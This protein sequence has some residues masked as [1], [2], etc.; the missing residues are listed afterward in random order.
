M[1][2]QTTTRAAESDLEPDEIYSVLAAADNIPKWAPVFADRIERTGSPDEAFYN[3]TKG[4]ESF[5]VEVILHQ[6]AG[7]VDYVREMAGNKRGGAY[8]R[9]TPRPRGGST[10]SMT[11][12]IGPDTDESDVAK[13]VDQELADLVR[14]TESRRSKP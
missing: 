7:T 8:L 6:A 4:A 9:V 14:L 2:L 12:P 13:T 11:V 5:R 10:V 1:R 3:V